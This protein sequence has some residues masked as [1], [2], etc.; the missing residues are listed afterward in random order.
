MIDYNDARGLVIRAN[1]TIKDSGFAPNVIEKAT[2]NM[3]AINV[4]DKLLENRIIWIDGEITAEIASNII[5]S[6]LY[7]QTVE[8]HEDDDIT[9]YINSPGG[10]CRSGL[11]IYDVMQMISP[12]IVTINVGMAASMASILLAGGTKGKR[13]ALKNSR[14]LIHQPFTAM[15]GTIGPDE[16]I[17]EA[18]E[19]QIIKNQLFTILSKTTGKSIEELEKDTQHDFYLSAE[20]A[21]KYGVIDEIV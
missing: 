16:A 19:L 17:I 15:C 10:S 5:S 13:K 1:S 7:L 20:D 2:H 14:V 6:L 3:C 8:G 11:A 9:M 12:N 4:Y 21:L 18:K